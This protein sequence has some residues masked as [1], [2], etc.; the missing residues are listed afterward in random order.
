MDGQLSQDEIS[1]L[2]AG[3]ATDDSNGNAEKSVD[4]SDYP[5]ID[6]TRETLSEKSQI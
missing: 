4:P 3:M 1:A 5:P 2:L 6:E